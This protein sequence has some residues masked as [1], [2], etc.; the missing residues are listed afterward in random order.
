MNTLK[1]T[2]ARARLERRPIELNRHC[3]ERSDEATQGRRDATL[4]ALAITM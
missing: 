3:E 1:I 4:A 2:E